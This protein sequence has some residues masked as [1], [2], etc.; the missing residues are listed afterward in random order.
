VTAK[1]PRVSL[2][3]NG[4]TVNDLET[5]VNKGYLALEAEGYKIEF[6]NLKLKKL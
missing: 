6:R 1:G 5:P 4:A 3:V 2:W